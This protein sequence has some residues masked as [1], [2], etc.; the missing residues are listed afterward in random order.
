[1][2]DFNP[3]QTE[4]DSDGVGDECDNCPNDINKIDPGSCGCGASDI[5]SDIDG[6]PDCYDNCPDD[7]LKID[8]GNCDCGISDIDTDSDGSPDCND[9]CDNDLNKIQP[10]ICGC[11]VAETDTDIDGIADCIEDEGPNGGD[12]NDDLILDSQQKNVTSFKT[13]DDQ[14][15]VTL[16]S[17]AGTTIA[18]CQAVGNPSPGDSPADAD[19]EYGL[20]S[21][22]ISGVAPGA[23]ISVI[24]DFHSGT[25][26]DTYWKYGFTPTN[27]SDHWYEF[28]YDGNTGAEINGNEITLHF[29]NGERG[30]DDINP[31][32]TVI[33]DVGGPGN[34]NQQELQSG[35]GSGGGG[36]FISTATYGFSMSKEIMAVVILISFSL[37]VLL[38]IRRRVK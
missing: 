17:D 11:G 30:D 33:I 22:T 34:N 10:G 2:Y 5:D 1:M 21:F 8:A 24:L 37:A 6:T 12:G 26:P 18:S 35:G 4:S 13:Y 25:A 29:V 14:S 36:C 32:N 3:D 23:A 31:T 20:F 19:F 15:Y 9:G 28:L 7:P 16:E 27:P 38:G